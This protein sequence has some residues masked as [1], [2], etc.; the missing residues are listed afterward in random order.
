MTSKFFRLALVLGLLSAIGPFAIDM[1]LPALP[2]I[3]RGLD[4]DVAGV[5][6]SLMSFFLAIALGQLF[7]GPAADLYGRKAPL[8]AGL[9]LFVA[10]SLGCAL[11][12]NIET[13]VVFRFVAGLGGAAVGVIPRA[14]VR[15]LYTGSEAARLMSLLLLVFSVSPLLAPLAGSLLIDVAGW[16]SV[17]WATGAIGVVGLA[18]TVSLIQETRDP[19]E[20]AQSSWGGTVTAFGE[21]LRDRH[22]MGLTLIGAFGMSAFFVFLANSSFVMIDHYGLTPRQYSLAFSFNAL[23]FFAFAQFT[24]RLTARHGL[25]KVVKGAVAS[26]AGTLTLLAVLFAAGV[27]HLGVLIGLMFIGFGFLGLVV[28][29]TSVLAL[30][31]HGAVAGTASALMGTLQ[32]LVGAAL[33]ALG[34][35]FFDGTALP[36]VAGIAGCAITALAFT[37]GTLGAAP[38]RSEAG[39]PPA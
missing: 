19:A 14:I 32:L 26:F 35:R 11:A 23:A 1:Y 10:G 28:P 25:V 20:R 38:A 33:M 2:A 39:A 17:F 5:Q 24:G 16:R 29:T 3:G 8:Y 18:M 21:L 13:L 22:F 7:Y 27:D 37:W 4:T 6:A 34:G 30:D 15:D 9:A 12:P 36:M 31:D